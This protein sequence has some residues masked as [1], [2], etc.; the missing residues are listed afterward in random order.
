MAG[1]T[2]TMMNNGHQDIKYHFVYVVRTSQ[3]SAL[4]RYW[5]ETL[6]VGELQQ[7]FFLAVVA[8][9]IGFETSQAVSAR[10]IVSST[11]HFTY[12]PSPCYSK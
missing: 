6:F 5:Q 11:F 1:G 9:V 3:S 12:Y 4:P 7:S 8:V 10:P 2:G